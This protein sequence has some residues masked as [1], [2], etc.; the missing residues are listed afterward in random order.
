MDSPQPLNSLT[1]S[2]EPKQCAT[3]CKSFYRI[4]RIK[5]KGALLILVWSFLISGLANLSMQYNQRLVLDIQLIVCGF[6]ILIAGW[7]ADIYFGRYRV[8]HWSMWIGW[9]SIVVSASIAI[10]RELVPDS[11]SHTHGYV[12]G[13]FLIIGAVGYGGLLSQCCTVWNRSAL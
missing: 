10:V 13:I 9:I 3:C 11:Y 8:I 4:R 12:S 6:I 1:L 5:D 2:D 7:L